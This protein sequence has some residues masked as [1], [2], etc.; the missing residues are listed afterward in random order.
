MGPDSK[1]GVKT[2]RQIKRNLSFAA[3]R[4]WCDVPVLF[5]MHQKCYSEQDGVTQ[6]IKLRNKALASRAE[7]CMNYLKA[8]R[9][10]RFE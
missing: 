6:A 1:R 9:A 8:H 7:Y 4:N 2:E 10:G 3:L 5:T